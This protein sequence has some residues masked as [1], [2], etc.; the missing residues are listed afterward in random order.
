[1]SFTDEDK[2]WIA[3]AIGGAISDSEARLSAKIERV[4]TSLLSSQERLNAKIDSVEERL[5]AKIDSV[6]A[7]LN[8]KIERVETSLLTEFHKWASPVEMRMRTHAAA[9][10]AVDLEIE[11]LSDRVTKLEPPH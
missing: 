6:E 8:S 11:A 7:R 10:R 1:M 2:Q 5:N 3:S 4:E 9:L